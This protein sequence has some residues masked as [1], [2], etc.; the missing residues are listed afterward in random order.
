VPAH[1]ILS[2]SLGPIVEVSYAL[3]PARLEDVGVLAVIDA[4][5]SANPWSEGQFNAACAE[6]AG[7]RN[8][9]LVVHQLDQ[10][11]QHNPID[12]F[13]VFSQ[14]LDEASVHNIA[15]RSS[16]QGRG[17]GHL[18]LKASMEQ[19]RCAG[20]VRCLLEVR[21]SNTAAR[22]LYEG[23]GFVPDGERKNYYPGPPTRENAVL[24]SRIL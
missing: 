4:S 24:M 19:M 22:R 15:V 9:V 11:D 7:G 20:A 12:G 17:L 23:H 14:V 2:C 5:A 16:R 3:R 10:L 6:S 13:I 8:T 21:Q 1:Q 18:L